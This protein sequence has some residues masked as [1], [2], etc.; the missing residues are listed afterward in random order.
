MLPPGELLVLPDSGYSGPLNLWRK[1][2]C[3]VMVF[4]SGCRKLCALSYAN[5]HAWKGI[6]CLCRPA[7]VQIADIVS[8]A[9][10]QASGTNIA[11][12]LAQQTGGHKA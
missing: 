7:N 10:Y 5:G 9:T 2:A 3:L 1:P 12:V 8:Y 4:T 11:R 6:L